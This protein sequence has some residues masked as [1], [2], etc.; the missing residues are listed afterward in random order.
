MVLRDT[1]SVQLCAQT[2]LFAMLL[3]FAGGQQYS[4]STWTNLLSCN[5]TSVANV[6]NMPPYNAAGGYFHTNPTSQA[7]VLSFEDVPMTVSTS[8]KVF[9]RYKVVGFLSSYDIW[10]LIKTMAFGGGSAP[11][12]NDILQLY[13][14]ETSNTQTVLWTPTGRVNPGHGTGIIP[15]PWAGVWTSVMLEWKQQTGKYTVSWRFN[16]TGACGACSST[17][18]QSGSATASGT[19]LSFYSG[20][21]TF[22]VGGGDSNTGFANLHV[23][24]VLISNIADATW[25]T[26][27]ELSCSNNFAAL[28]S[29]STTPP[30]SLHSNACPVGTFKDLYSGECMPCFGAQY[31]PYTNATAC[32]ACPPNSSGGAL[33]IAESD[34][35]CKRER[36]CCL[37]VLNL[38]S[39]TL[40]CIRQPR[41]RLRVL[42]VCGFV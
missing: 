4:T 2:M 10:F 8:F 26:S 32:L 11:G 29:P 39:S 38:V 33:N 17:C 13:R 30:V 37:L 23:S 22:R 31:N 28:I 3:A 14:Y 25:P 35:V 19:L 7:Q 27:D 6:K 34:C 42:D 41:P 9:M 18:V 12:A 1:A 5:R 20:P 24:H 15:N 16:C 21:Y 40:P 36:V